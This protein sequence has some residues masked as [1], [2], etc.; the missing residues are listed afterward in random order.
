MKRKKSKPFNPIKFKGKVVR[1]V[2]ELD[3]MKDVHPQRRKAK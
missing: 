2:W 1:E 3:G